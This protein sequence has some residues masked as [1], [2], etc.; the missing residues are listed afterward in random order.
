MKKQIIIVGKKSFIAINI[1][2]FLKKKFQVKLLSYEDIEDKSNFSKVDYI[3]NCSSNLNYVKKKYSSK[4][5]FDYLIS[6]KITNYK[7]CKQVF[8]SS[9]K[10][11][12]PTKNI[13]ENGL[14][15][16]RE[17][18]SKNKYLT[19]KK[20][21]KN[22]PDQVLILRISNLIGLPNLRGRKLHK[23]FIDYYLENIKKNKIIDNKNIYKDFL[24]VGLFVK[25]IFLL[26]KK[27]KLG[28][29]N[30][31]I[32]KKVYLKNIIDWLNYYNPNKGFLVTLKNQNYNLLNRDSFYLNNRKLM[33]AINIKISLNHLKKECLGISK[34]IFYEKK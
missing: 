6:K 5:D 10:I 19:E 33:K 1:Y 27:N 29:F 21:L 17:N 34:K 24:P 9:R 28:I 11:Y 13:R 20:L 25:I 18:Y 32:G 16:L 23:T 15:S 3:I 8:L 14:V 4:Y 26:I 12:R 7:N 22:I 2:R 31:S 30:V